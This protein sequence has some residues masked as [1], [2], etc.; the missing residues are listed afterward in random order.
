MWI[1]WFLWTVDTAGVMLA[2]VMKKTKFWE[3]PTA[4]TLNDP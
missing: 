4:C 1:S 3:Q 2:G